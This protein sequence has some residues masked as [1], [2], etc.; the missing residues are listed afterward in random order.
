MERQLESCIKAH[1]FEKDV[2]SWLTKKARWQIPP[3]EV[4]YSH[5]YMTKTNEQ[6]QFVWLYAQHK[7]GTNL[8]WREQI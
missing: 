5:Y 7:E 6:H 4:N 8:F 3:K 2:K 1:Q